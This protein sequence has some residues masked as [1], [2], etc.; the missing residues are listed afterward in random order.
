MHC[1]PPSYPP[2]MY[3]NPTPKSGALDPPL[4]DI[5]VAPSIG[6]GCTRPPHGGGSMCQ[7]QEAH[8]WWQGFCPPRRKHTKHS[9]FTS[10]SPGSSHNTSPTSTTAS[11]RYSKPWATY[12]GEFAPNWCCHRSFSVANVFSSRDCVSDCVS[13][14]V[15]TPSLR[16]PYKALC[17]RLQSTICNLY[18]P[19]NHIASLRPGLTHLRLKVCA[20]LPVMLCLHTT[21]QDGQLTWLIKW[22]MGQ[23][24]RAALPSTLTTD[25]ALS[26]R[27]WIFAFAGRHVPMCANVR[28][29]FLRVDK[30]TLWSLSCRHPVTAHTVNA[31]LPKSGR[32]HRWWRL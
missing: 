4:V 29:C 26:V 25:E 11:T 15:Q 9:T 2:D 13:D 14:C 17:E 3:R 24:T 5:H 28:P 10:S 6:P 31:C 30:K 8:G 20:N 19:P 16:L 32:P 12:K 22:G 21:T 23:G 1:A 18:G 7:D 27:D